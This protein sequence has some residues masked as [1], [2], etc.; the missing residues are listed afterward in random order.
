MSKEEMKMDK[1]NE[2]K[3]RTTT[4]QEQSYHVKKTSAAAMLKLIFDIKPLFLPLTML[5]QLLSTAIVFVNIILGAKILDG[6]AVQKEQDLVQLAAIMVSCNLCFALLRWGINKWLIIMRREIN[7]RILKQVYEKCLTLDYQIMERTETLDYIQKANV[8]SQSQGGI[9]TYCEVI[10]KLFANITTI[11]YSVIILT[12]F[13]KSTELKEGSKLLQFFNSPQAGILLAFLLILI[14]FSRYVFSKKNQQLGYQFFE[15]N[16]KVNREM[17]HYGSFLWNYQMGKQVRIYQILPLIRTR[18]QKKVQE[19]E[20]LNRKNRRKIIQVVVP[21]EAIT[22][23][24]FIICYIF[25]GLKAISGTISI[26]SLS[27]YVGALTGFSDALSE[28]FRNINVLS[29]QNQYLGNYTS[30]LALENEKYNGTLPIEKRLD[31]DYELE[32]RNVSFH[33]PNSEDLVLKNI[34]AKIHVGKKMAIVG[35]NGSGKST[36]IKLLCRLY[37]PTEGE[38]LLNGIDIKKYDY[39]EYRQIFGVVFQDFRLFSFSVAQN[40]AADVEYDK[41]KVWKVLWQA[42]MAERVREMEKGIET[43]LYKQEDEGVEISGG[44]AQKLAIARALYKD[45]PVVILDEPTAALDPVS[46]LEIYERFNEMVEEKTAVY[47]SHRMSSCRFCENILVFEDGDIVQIGSHDKLVEE[48]G[49]YA[50]LWEAQAQY[51]QG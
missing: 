42:G 47:I 21:S 31:N 43:V 40:V 2:T 22:G 18:L 27:L 24:F 13:F 8:G 28:I 7:E 23:I 41:E 16:V 17:G 48:D 37:D 26:G 34:T 50:R 36:F 9:V 1:N 11:V 15:D 30:F 19:A 3:K 5:E 20:E 32:F 4:H 51:Y 39:D 44:E 33:Y 35:K 49:L 25:V 46:E 10:S 14:I 45:A 6:L 12:G 38:I 29:I